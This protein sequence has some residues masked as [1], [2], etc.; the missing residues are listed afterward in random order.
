[1][2]S[3]VSNSV[4]NC[5]VL[6]YMLAKENTHVMHTICHFYIS[7]GERNPEFEV[8][9]GLRLFQQVTVLILNL[10]IFLYLNN[11]FQDM[12]FID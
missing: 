1:M 3:L 7:F 11:L 5:T 6:L 12:K 2:F 8:P 10:Q 4:V 9:G